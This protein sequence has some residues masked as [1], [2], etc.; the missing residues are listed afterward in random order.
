MRPHL[1]LL[2]N[3]C[4]KKLKSHVQTLIG[5]LIKKRMII[6]G[7]GNGSPTW[8]PFDIADWLYMTSVEVCFPQQPITDLKWPLCWRTIHYDVTVGTTNK[9]FYVKFQLLHTTQM[10]RPDRILLYPLNLIF[11]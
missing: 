9:S 5:N 1:P 10:S 7:N 3:F 11:V 8:R 2:T 4:M 6:S